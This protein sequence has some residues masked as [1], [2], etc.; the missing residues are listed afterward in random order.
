MYNTSYIELSES[1]LQCNLKFIRSKKAPTCTLSH[2]IKG[3]AYGH[4]IDKFV[5]LLY[6]NGARHFSVFDAGEA[7]EVIKALGQKNFTL[8]IMGMIE[9]QQ[10]EWAIEQEVEY[11]VYDFSRLEQSIKVAKKVKR[12]ACIHIELETGMNRTGFEKAHW[13]KVAEMCLANQEHL[14]IKG[15]CT[16]Y[17]G[18]ESI[19]NHIRVAKQK[20]VFQKGTSFFIGL[21]LRPEKI[22]SSCSA[23]FMRVRN[24]QQDM[25]RIG[26]LQYGFWPSIET[27]IATAGAGKDPV[28]PL[29]RVM[30]WKSR[31][32]STKRVKKGEY[33]GYGTSYLASSEMKVA[34]V[35]IG[36]SHG[37]SRSLSNSGRALVHGTRVQVVGMV[38]M[39]VM[40]IDISHLQG[41]NIGDEVVL[42]GEQGEQSI[43]VSSFS[44]YSE[45]LN[46]ELLTRLPHNIPRY[47]V[48]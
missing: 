34:C 6:K 1:A 32:M 45:Q 5:P 36:Y 10:I 40:M 17:A 46:Y 39:N 42:I 31:I 4:G 8:L 28:D 23:A 3:N 30:S 33:I 7:Y 44:D 13:E 48:N 37:F 35:P 20:K 15:I 27:Y 22:H 43:S 41:V 19:A 11:Y 2:V 16:H 9:S 14:K 12:S 24:A 18:A 25:V 38:N 26:I 47:V 29:K 21:G